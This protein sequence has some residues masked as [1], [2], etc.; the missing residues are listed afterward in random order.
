[1]QAK[2]AGAVAQH[3]VK[4][5]IERVHRKHQE[6]REKGLPSG[7]GGP[8]GFKVGGIEHDDEEAALIVEATARILNGASLA[9]IIREWNE[10][11]VKTTRGGKWHYSSFTSMIRR[12]RNAGIREHKGEPVGPAAWEPIVTE[13]ELRK[14]RSVLDSR[15]AGRTTRA[16]VGST[17]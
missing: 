2:V 7:G 4:H 8:F 10:A 11:G 14:P 1:M 13:D 16:S 12:W 3:E 9:S 15:S 17:C 6:L 5:M